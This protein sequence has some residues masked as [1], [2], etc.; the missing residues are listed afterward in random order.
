M[1]NLWKWIEA[2]RLGGGRDEILEKYMSRPLSPFRV[3]FPWKKRRVCTT[4]I[5]NNLRERTREGSLC[6][7]WNFLSIL[8]RNS[9]WLTWL[10]SQDSKIFYS[11]CVI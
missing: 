1:Y 5:S 8:L 4:R 7:N 2:G 11:N 3:F 9:G 10:I 6:P